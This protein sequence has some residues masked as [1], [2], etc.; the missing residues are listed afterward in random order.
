MFRFGSVLFISFALWAAD[1]APL[2]LSLRRAVEIAT[3]PEGNARIQVSN[4][5]TAQAK[6]RATQARASL[7]PSLDGAVTKENMNR[8][9][10][11]FG[12]QLNNL[13]AGFQF[14]SVVGPFDLFD[15]RLTASQSVF[16]FGSIRR[17]QASR[18][19]TKAAQSD[20]ASTSDEVAAQVAK[21]YLAAL[22]SDADTAT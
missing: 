4:E 3:S 16:D 6:A 7:L 1:R 12:L 9:L 11:A 18:V 22:R 13:P 8:S 5:L 14:P 15:G 2:Q 17:Y 10:A 20:T 21:A 19:G